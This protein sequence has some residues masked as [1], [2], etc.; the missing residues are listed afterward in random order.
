MFSIRT[1]NYMWFVN[2]LSLYA[3]TVGGRSNKFVHCKF[4][5]AVS[6]KEF[7]V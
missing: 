2:G 4:Y 5:G 3:F 7:C 6:F 1:T